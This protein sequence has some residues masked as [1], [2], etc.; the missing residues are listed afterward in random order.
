MSCSDRRAWSLLS[1]PDEERVFQGNDGYGDVTG[2]SYLFDSRVPNSRHVSLEDLIMLRDGRSV[3]GFGVVSDIEMSM[4]DKTIR[5]CPHC[6]SSKLGRRKVKLP[7]YRCQKCLFE[8]NTPLESSVTVA[9]FAAHYGG[10][11][12]PLRSPLPVTAVSGCYY[13][14]AAQH[15]IRELVVEALLS[16]PQVRGIVGPLWLKP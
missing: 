13:G 5:T 8:T 4:G 9:R 11:W 7:E 16:H 15:A 6:G 1:L 10:S 3:L 12:V 14:N 2:R